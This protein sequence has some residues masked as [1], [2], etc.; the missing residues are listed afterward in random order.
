MRGSG[1]LLVCEYHL[2]GIKQ[3]RLQAETLNLLEIGRLKDYVEDQ[4]G[5]NHA[6]RLINQGLLSHL[7]QIVCWR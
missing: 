4:P 3:E 6:E 5:S 1:F 2:I 7:N